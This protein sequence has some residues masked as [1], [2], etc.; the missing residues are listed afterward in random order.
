[1]NCYT[2][3]IGKTIT[4]VLDSVDAKIK[5]RYDKVMRDAI[6]LYEISTKG[7]HLQTKWISS[8]DELKNLNAKCMQCISQSDAEEKP[9]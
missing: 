9:K 1:M 6:V 7:Y 2:E 5:E 3:T 4:T 8:H